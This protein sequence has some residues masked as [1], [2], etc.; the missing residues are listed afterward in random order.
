[1]PI[2]TDPT[3]RQHRDS[4]GA[5]LHQCLPLSGWKH[6][7]RCALEAL[8]AAMAPRLFTS[9]AFGA[10]VIGLCMAVTP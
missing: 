8:D 2:A 1:M 6:R 4:L 9:V 5:H 7:G 10:V 3:L